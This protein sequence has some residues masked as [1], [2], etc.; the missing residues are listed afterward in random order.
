MHWTV[1]VQPLCAML[2]TKSPKPFSSAADHSVLVTRQVSGW[3][4]AGKLMP[5]DKRPSAR[6]VARAIVIFHPILRQP[7][8]EPRRLISQ[9]MRH[10]N[11]RR[12]FAASE[13]HR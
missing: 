11:R 2:R 6:T 9:S 8:F 4:A 10:F 1:V 7:V 3:A 12:I 13:L 5:N